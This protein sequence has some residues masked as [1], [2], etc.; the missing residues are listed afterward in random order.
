M[1]TKKICDYAW[2]AGIID[3]EGSTLLTGI[4][5][6]RYPRSKTQYKLRLEVG[7]SSD[8]GAPD[9]LIRLSEL[10]GGF[11][12]KQPARE[13]RKQVYQWVLHG[14]ER[15]QFAL[16]CMWQWLTPEK[17]GQAKRALETYNLI[18]RGHRGCHIG[19]HKYRKE[20]GLI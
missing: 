9:M 10:Y 6:P 14:H 2:S 20:E 4:N 5:D 13:N 12:R 17:K 8:N 3:G 11:V 1:L 18:K 19:T 15:V 16:A 7:Q